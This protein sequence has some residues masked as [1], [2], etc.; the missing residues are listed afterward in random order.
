MTKPAAALS[1]FAHIFDSEERERPRDQAS[2]RLRMLLD[3]ASERRAD[4]L[5]WASQIPEPKAGK[6][7]FDRFPF[8]REMYA[9]GAYD[10]DMVLKKSTQVGV[11]AYLIRWTIFFAATRGQTALYIFPK[12]RQLKDFSDSRVRPLLQTEKLRPLV[13]ATFVQHKT[14]KQIGLGYVYYRG[15]E[16]TAGLESID[17][18]ALALDEYDFLV[19][20]NIPQAMHRLDGSLEPK[21]RR[22]GFPTYPDYGIAKFYGQSDQRQWL[23]KCARCNEWQDIDFFENVDTEAVRVVCRE[24]RKPLDVRRG[25]WVAQFP[26]RE[27]RGYHVPRLIVPTCDLK[28]LIDESKGTTPFQKQIFYNR[29]LGLEYATDENRLSS[30][31][32][33]AAQREDITRVGGY[34]GDN[35]VTMG[36]DVASAR[37]LNVRI[38]EHLSERTK[39]ALWIGLV[40]SFDDLVNLM[41]RYGVNMAV[42]DHLPEQ[43]LAYAFAERFAGRVYL[44]GYS[45]N[46]RDILSIEDEQRRIMVR[47][48]E[49]IDATLEQIRRQHNLLPADLPENYSDNLMAAIRFAE[50]DELGKMVVGYRKTGPDDYL[51]A[52]V[53]D[54]IA[55]EAWYIRQRVEDS[56]REVLQPL[57]D[58]ME[59]QRSALDDSGDLEYRAG[60]E[61]TVEHYLDH[62]E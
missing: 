50:E 26:D 2:A 23:V 52:E 37:A 48:V 44:C 20:E 32:I 40:D 49:A 6:M 14:L 54:L 1:G 35:I 16:S 42:I 21:V 18:D 3:K 22:V 25:Q 51:H 13:P 12:E 31:A 10:R 9:E 34:R 11:S 55:T 8:Q 5:E 61:E 57:D 36:V 29:A 7:D 30:A 19:P 17:A 41:E 53:Y 27:V 60:P 59:F 45:Q 56:Q 24:C 15:S 62:V 33:A 39:K 43:R 4:F 46:Q 38:S 58:L 47:R 28:G